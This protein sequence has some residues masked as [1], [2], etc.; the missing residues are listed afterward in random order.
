MNNFKCALKFLLLEN[1]LKTEFLI[2]DILLHC[3]CRQ[4]SA[5]ESATRLNPNLDVY[6]FFVSPV[7]EANSK[8]Y[9]K[10]K[11]YLNIKYSFLEY[12]FITLFKQYTN[13]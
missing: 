3:C 8:L 6:T 13:R 4:V 10:L 5:I 9:D 7:N 2:Y 11:Q 12:K 1:N